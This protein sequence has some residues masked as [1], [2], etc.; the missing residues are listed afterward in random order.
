MF[1]RLP[2][3]LYIE[4][5]EKEHVCSFSELLN[6][7]FRAD[8]PGNEATKIQNCTQISGEMGEP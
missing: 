7:H 6:M 5:S 1:C 3:Q 8:K 4:H 2:N